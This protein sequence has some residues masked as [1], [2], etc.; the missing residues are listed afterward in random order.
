LED[1]LFSR[2][3]RE[4]D[5][6]IPDGVGIVFASR[7]LRGNIHE[8]VTGSDI[9]RGIHEQLDRAGGGSVF[10]LGSSEE[11]L[12]TIQGRMARDFRNVRVV[13]SCSPPF[14]ASF[15]A[16]DTEKMIATINAAAPDVLWIGM[17]SPK[18]DVW[19]HQ[20]RQRLKVKFAAGVGAVFD[21]YSGRVKRSH[22]VF[23]RLGIEWL[24]RL[25][26]EPRRLWRRML[27]SAPVF[28]WHLVRL[29]V[30]RSA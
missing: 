6:L 28:L 18:Q 9:F 27:I 12:A 4:V 21:F 19:L 14:K 7:L 29:K 22:P 23:Q 26:Q 10:F 13:G 5:W 25:L 20:N 15:S 17:T 11:T 1:S 3:L 16:E 8:R 24:P 30:R 2:T